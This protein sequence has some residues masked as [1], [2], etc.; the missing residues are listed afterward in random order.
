[1]SQSELKPHRRRGLSLSLRVSLLLM[2]A[3]I[4]PLLIT[5]TSIELLSR[6]ALVT[7][8]NIA[9][10]SDVH[11]RVQLIDTYLNER[12]LDVGTLTQVPSLVAFMATPPQL[13][14]QDLTVHAGY[15]LAAGIYRD[16]HYTTWALFDPQGHL[17][18]Y[19]P[20]TTPPAPRGHRFVGSWPAWPARGVVARIPDWIRSCLL[21]EAGRL[22]DDLAVHDRRAE[23][24][25]IGMVEARDLGPVHQEETAEAVFLARDGAELGA[26]DVEG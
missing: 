11:S 3:A 7:Q 6:P 24:A 21:A 20:T 1:M 2:F 25:C 16:K 18:L 9:M 23:A 14:T 12:L 15:A 17:R 19:Y 10:E 13:A 22:L 4:V 5:V 26:Q 8:A